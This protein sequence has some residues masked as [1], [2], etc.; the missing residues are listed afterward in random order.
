[1]SLLNTF[2]WFEATRIGTYGRHSTYFFPSVEVGHLFGLTLLLGT[3]LV[4]NLRL[5][6]A[7]MP[8]PSIPEIARAT[9][10]LLWT[11]VAL[12]VG[13]G[14]LL[15]LAEA[16]KCYYNVAFW[17]KMGL[18]I[19]AIVFQLIVH[20][21]LKVAPGPS[22]SYTKGTAVMSLVLWFGVAVAG[23]AIAFV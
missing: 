3:V 5:L 12:T 23:R 7:I 2:H 22:T 10:P 20:Q 9:T 6:G 21:K 17:Y 13:S 16:I 14:L 4:L 15:F 8:R 18:L 11:G 19:S 1:M